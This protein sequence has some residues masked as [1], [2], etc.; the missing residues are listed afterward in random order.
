VVEDLN[1]IPPRL[2]EVERELHTVKHRVS[3]LE[4]AH[5]DAPIRLSRLEVSVSRL[6]EIERQLSGQGEQIRRGF[7]T[8]NGILLGA[9]AMWFLFQAGPAILKYIGG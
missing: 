6:P 3:S 7:N 1:T 4:E 2:N 9:G 5:K 8:V